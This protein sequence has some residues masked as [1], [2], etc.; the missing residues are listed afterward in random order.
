MG[1]RTPNQ[2]AHAAPRAAP[3]T[4]A[5]GQGAQHR[6]PPKAGQLEGQQRRGG[7]HVRCTCASW[8]WRLVLKQDNGLGGGLSGQIQVLLAAHH[9]RGNAAVRVAVPPAVKVAQSKPARS[10]CSLECQM[11][12]CR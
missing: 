7:P 5:V 3:L 12:A 1:A 11:A 9:A 2:Q 8:D 6:Q 4:R 10:M